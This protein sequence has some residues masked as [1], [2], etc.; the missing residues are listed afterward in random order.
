MEINNNR[1]WTKED[2]LIA[3]ILKGYGVSSICK[4]QLISGKVMTFWRQGNE[5]GGMPKGIFQALKINET[6]MLDEIIKGNPDKE[7]R[8]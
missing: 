6:V 1:R 4:M 5:M 3:K 7:K 2:Q 8:P